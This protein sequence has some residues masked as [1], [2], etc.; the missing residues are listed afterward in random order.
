MPKSAMNWCKCLKGRPLKELTAIRCPATAKFFF[1]PRDEE[2]LAFILRRL[3]P[4]KIQCLILGAGSNILAAG[5]IKRAVIKLGA[6]AF[7]KIVFH[8]GGVYAGAGAR[9]N[10][11]VAQA[12]GRGLSGAEFLCG[13]PGTLGGAL[14]MNAGAWGES[15][16]DLVENVRVMDYNSKIKDL[17]G[18]KIKFAYRE[19]GLGRYII[20]AARLKL[21]RGKR[22][23]IRAGIS[24]YL[25][26][27]AGAQDNTF[28][29]CGCVF[30]NP[31]AQMP[32]GRLID[33]CGLKGKRSGGAMISPKHANF[34]L[35]YNHASA[36]DVLRLMAF[37]KTAVKKRFGV[38]LEPEVKIWR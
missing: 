38:A 1:E 10:R 25:R 36:A 5:K 37:M 26:R 28:P 11:I 2:D 22:A 3:K 24:A 16:G 32:A 30:K 35:N 7:K 18:R 15:I 19:S 8:K 4:G 9:L 14:A 29:N 21:R 23:A 27:R 20:L 34:I 33:L 31:A 12:A 17:P 13:I 6:P